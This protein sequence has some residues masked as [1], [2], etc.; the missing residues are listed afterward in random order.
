MILCYGQNLISRILTPI[1]IWKCTGDAESAKA[2]CEKY[3]SVG[4]QFLKIRKII[5]DTSIPRRLELYHNLELT[6]EK[7]VVI[8]LY[9]ETL[10]GIINSYVDR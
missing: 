2:F 5:M 4:D 8:K 6:E 1:H 10:E 9:P 7:N 3:S